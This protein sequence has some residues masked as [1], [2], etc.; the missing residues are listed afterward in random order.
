M[1]TSIKSAKTPSKIRFNVTLTTDANRA[2][3]FMARDEQRSKS[4]MLEILIRKETVRFQQ[5]AKAA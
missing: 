4:N 5:E 3:K 2:L 1:K